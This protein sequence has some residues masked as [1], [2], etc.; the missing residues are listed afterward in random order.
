MV[1]APDAIPALDRDAIY[2]HF[3]TLASRLRAAQPQAIVVLTTDHLQN[4]FFNN[5]PAVC[6]GAATSYETPLELWFKA[7]ARTIPGDAALGQYLLEQALSDGFEP[8]FSMDL[9]LDHGTLT[10]LHLAGLDEL[11]IV[12]IMI[13]CVQPPMPSMARCLQWGEFLQRALAGYP[14]LERVAILATGGLSHA[15]GTP[16]MGA[17]NESF[18]PRLPGQTRKP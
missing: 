5:F 14:D 16:T 8:S 1:N 10:P 6:I 7:D 17:T 9:T 4:F 3:K 11:A 2:S 15:I 18:R 12:P 13:N